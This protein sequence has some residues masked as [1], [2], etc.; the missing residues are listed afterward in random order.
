MTIPVDSADVRELEDDRATSD[1]Q[2]GDPR[3]VIVSADRECC[4][5]C[6]TAREQRVTAL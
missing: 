2:R 6:A 4:P 5:D 3:G 1:N